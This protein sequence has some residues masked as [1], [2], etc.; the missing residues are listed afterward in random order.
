MSDSTP[1]N[2]ADKPSDELSD[3]RPDQ[4][5][6]QRPNP[7]QGPRPGPRA[8]KR[9]DKRPDPP[10]DGR[11]AS[12]R[13]ALSLLGAGG[14]LAGSAT[15]RMARA[16]TGSS[17]P[18]SWREAG[19]GFSNYGLPPEDSRIIRWISAEP[20]SPGT[21][22]SWT[23][24]HELEGTV[25]PNGLH[26]ERHHGGVPTIDPLSWTLAIDGKVG[27]ALRF[28]LERLT[29]RPMR[30][31]FAFLECGGNSSSLWREQA[32]QAPAGWLHGLVSSGEWT[33]V[34]LFDLLDEAGVLSDA[35]W[36]IATG[37]DAAGVS[38]SLPMDSLPEDTLVALFR[39]GEPLR[40]EHGSPARLL[41][42]GQEGICN[43][44][45]LGRLTLADRPAMSRFDTVSYTDLGRD[46]IA[47]RF[48]R[49][50]GVKSVVT[51]PSVGER[52]PV[53]PV[54]ITGLAWSGAGRI[55]RVEV[56][57]DGGKSWADAALDGEPL[58]RAFVRFRFAWNRA[59]AA[60]V[61][62]QSR[63]H[64]A[65]G[66]VQPG[67]ATLLAAHGPN[68]HYHYNAVLT[69]GIEADGRVVNLHA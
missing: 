54:A 66:R 25:T 31:R 19:G 37:L 56:S 45:W 42:P 41:V 33:G 8:N 57:V 36:L 26:F 55:A 47:T 9:A 64:D 58:D 16:A 14:L 30:S 49:I 21:G 22:A 7:R 34:L 43:V 10:P 29:A 60:P 68:H 62:V 53:G 46:G 28:D 63:A 3:K 2:P 27:E 35:R 12:R 67:R 15:G 11:R 6:D 52:V 48:S 5:P 40:R 51:S 4:R 17:V 39:N 59:Q 69:L 1:Q 23:P 18:P 44:K 61:L 32:V 50:M 38:V 24:L 65:S 13:R 20:A